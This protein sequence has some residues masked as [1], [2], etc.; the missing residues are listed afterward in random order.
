MAAQPAFAQKPAAQAAQP[1]R[2]FKFSTAEKA[3]LL[4]VQTA[5]T[6]KDW[7]KATS[8]LPAAQVG[9]YS[10]TLVMEAEQGITTVRT[11]PH[12]KVWPDEAPVFTRLPQIAADLDRRL[13]LGN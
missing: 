2:A 9:S 4:P 7:A 13:G 1:T 6:A 12:W 8:L 3:A 11:L 10:A 5:I